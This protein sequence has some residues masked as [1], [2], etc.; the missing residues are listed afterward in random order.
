MPNMTAQQVSSQMAMALWS[1]LTEVVDGLDK[2]V[3]CCVK[4]FE[5]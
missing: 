2:R 4:S 3:S 5:F 1:G